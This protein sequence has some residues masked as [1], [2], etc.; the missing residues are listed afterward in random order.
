MLFLF[1]V[2]L[3]DPLSPIDSSPNSP[4]PSCVTT[5]TVK[6]SQTLF[7][8]SIVCTF[9]TS[10]L[11][12]ASSISSLIFRVYSISSLVFVALLLPNLS[13]A[14]RVE[15]HLIYLTQHYLA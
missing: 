10:T 1:S 15:I 9:T 14:V 3:L 8:P 11:L 13:S 6:G 4:P 2:I 7:P 5:P 12:S